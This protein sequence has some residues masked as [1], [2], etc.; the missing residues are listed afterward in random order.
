MPL[1][2]DAPLPMRVSEVRP[3]EGSDS[4]DPYALVE[5]RLPDEAASRGDLLEASLG[6]VRL[7]LARACT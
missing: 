4:G 5:P 2:G 7:V 1:V 3:V 6:Q